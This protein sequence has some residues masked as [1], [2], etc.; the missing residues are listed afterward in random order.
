MKY[1]LLYGCPAIVLPAKEGAPILA[2]HARTL[3]QLWKIEL[4][5]NEAALGPLLSTGEPPKGAEDKEGKS[6]Y[7][8]VVNALFEFLDQCTNWEWVELPGNGR[9]RNVAESERKEG[10][11][12]AVALLVAAAIRSRQSE[13]VLRQVQ[14]ERAGIAMWRIP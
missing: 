3:E 14:K 9:G 7:A 13:G 10:V 12:R 6:T 2:W 11:K 4:P 8:N 5:P 1:K